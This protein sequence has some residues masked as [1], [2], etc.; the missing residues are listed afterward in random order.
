MQAAIIP[1]H[2]IHGT[3]AGCALRVDSESRSGHV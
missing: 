1:F 3:S 2:G